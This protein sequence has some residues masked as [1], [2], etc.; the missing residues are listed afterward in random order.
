MLKSWLCGHLNENAHKKRVTILNFSFFFF[1]PKKVAFTCLSEVFRILSL[2]LTTPDRILL[3]ERASTGTR[4]ICQ[5]IFTYNTLQISS[6]CKCLMEC[7]HC[8]GHFKGNVT[9]R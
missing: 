4:P 3:S 7:D 5:I 2:N 1:H 6:V 9:D 8:L